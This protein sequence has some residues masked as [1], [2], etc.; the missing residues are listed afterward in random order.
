MENN[1]RQN[2]EETEKNRSRISWAQRF[3]LAL[4][5]L[6]IP[7]AEGPS[8]L[9]RAAKYSMPQGDASTAEPAVRYLVRA[10]LKDAL[11]SKW[12]GSANSARE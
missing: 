12:A 1:G 5:F 9:P 8:R 11:Q 3:S 2:G 4:L 6:T 7:S 10:S